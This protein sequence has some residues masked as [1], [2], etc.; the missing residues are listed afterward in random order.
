MI[1]GKRH[2]CLVFQMYFFR[3]FIAKPS[4]SVVPLYLREC[5]KTWQLIP[6]QSRWL[7][8]TTSK[9]ENVNLYFGGGVVNCPF[10]CR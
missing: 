9:K 2:F 6:E 10:E 8:N 5:F 1:S 7:N 3:A 4:A